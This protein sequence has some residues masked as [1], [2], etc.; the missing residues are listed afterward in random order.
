MQRSFVMHGK[1]CRAILQLRTRVHDYIVPKHGR[2]HARLT[3]AVIAGA[4]VA[5]NFPCH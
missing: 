1:S 2:H 4:P 3:G 5:E